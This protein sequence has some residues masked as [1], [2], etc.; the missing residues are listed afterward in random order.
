MTQHF[1]F[2]VRTESTNINDNI[3]DLLINI[4]VICTNLYC[5]NINNEKIIY[6]MLLNFHCN[7]IINTVI[8]Y[9]MICDNVKTFISN[10]ET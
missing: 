2:Y 10:G 4:K 6:L 3:N 7:I 5:I 8:K 1:S 9:R